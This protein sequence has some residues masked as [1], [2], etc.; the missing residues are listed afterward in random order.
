MD[1]RTSLL[2]ASCI[3]A[4]PSCSL[5]PGFI[6]ETAEG[7]GEGGA[8]GTSTSTT[9][10][11]AADSTG[12]EPYDTA[13]APGECSSP[14]VWNVAL[15]EAEAADELDV[16]L[17]L[18]PDGSP[19]VVVGVPG[20]FVAQRLDGSG[21]PRNPP[22]VLEDVPADD[23]GLFQFDIGPD[24]V[25]ALGWGRSPD[26]FWVQRRTPD[27]GAALWTVEHPGATGNGGDAPTEELRAL[28]VSE[29]G[30]I[31]AAYAT[32]DGFDAD[33]VVH[34]YDRDAETQWTARL[35]S[36]G[37]YD[38]PSLAEDAGG[39]LLAWSTG[40]SLR[41]HVRAWRLDQSGA[42]VQLDGEAAGELVS[43]AV[44]GGSGWI[45][46]SVIEDGEVDGSALQRVDEM[47]TPTPAVTDYPSP[48]IAWLQPR[49]LAAVGDRS[50]VFT[51]AEAD[52]DYVMELRVYAESGALEQV[53]GV[54]EAA[55][56]QLGDIYDVEVAADGSLYA[57]GTN[58][59]ATQHFQLWLRR[60]EL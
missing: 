60:F 25:V 26:G 23:A 1:R 34:A 35:E 55:G 48:P 39:T 5:G 42:I 40:S 2:L 45:F 53:H 21:Q 12:A 17:A 27:V 41:T 33:L 30:G 20:A 13:G 31:W 6:G 38:W 22:V 3:F 18:E 49:V 4:L 57:L 52:T 44:R 47:L 36:D 9:G 8:G 14:C 28:F 46:A 58:R 56:T 7:S 37:Q 54:G 59:D 50:A 19:V 43:P 29:A 10:D 32:V 11:G 15:D 16:H 24:G 51:L